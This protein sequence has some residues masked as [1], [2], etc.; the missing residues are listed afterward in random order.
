M[1]ENSLVVIDEFEL[2]LYLILEIEFVFLLKMV[3]KLFKLKVIFVIYFL[4]VVREVFLK[5]VYIFRDEGYGLDVVFFLFE[6]F[7]GDM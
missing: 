7:G 4:V 3:L 5:C 1:K 6:M 2:F